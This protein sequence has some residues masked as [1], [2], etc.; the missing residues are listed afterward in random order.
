M[1]CGVK[2]D[3]NKHKILSVLEFYK[4]KYWDLFQEEQRYGKKK[5]YYYGA[6]VAT[7]EIYEKIMEVTEIITDC[8]TDEEEN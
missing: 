6:Y 8:D 2:M 4:Q 1:K 7:I 5:N 3:F